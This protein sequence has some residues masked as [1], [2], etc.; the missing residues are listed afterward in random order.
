[1][2]TDE[3]QQLQIDDPITRIADDGVMADVEITT[4]PDRLDDGELRE[5]LANLDTMLREAPDLGTEEH[6]VL[7]LRE[8]WTELWDEYDQRGLEPALPRQW[9]ADE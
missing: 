8:E 3:E 4:P 9:A 2:V 1:M 7:R 6:L 5:R